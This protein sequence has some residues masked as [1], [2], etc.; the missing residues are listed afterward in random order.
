MV[1]TPKLCNRREFRTPTTAFGVSRG[2]ATDANVTSTSNILTENGAVSEGWGVSLRNNFLQIHSLDVRYRLRHNVDKF[3]SIV[4]KITKKLQFV[5]ASSGFENLL[6][7]FWVDTPQDIF[8]LTA[9]PLAVNDGDVSTLHQGD[10]VR[11]LA[12][13]W[14]RNPPL[15]KPGKSGQKRTTA[16]MMAKVTDHLWTFDELFEKVLHG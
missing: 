2:R 11:E 5:G 7:S 12:H 14:L 8:R 1:A 10:L 16:A 9:S 3:P 4:A 6:D 13:A 15:P